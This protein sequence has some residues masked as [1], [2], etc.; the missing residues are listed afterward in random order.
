[1]ERPCRIV[2]IDIVYKFTYGFLC[3]IRVFVTVDK[4]N[5]SVHNLKVAPFLG[6]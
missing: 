6:D 3:I 5:I 4:L 2:Y 1:M